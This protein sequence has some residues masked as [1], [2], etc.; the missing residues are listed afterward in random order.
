MIDWFIAYSYFRYVIYML[1][2][3]INIISEIRMYILTGFSYKIR[4]YQTYNK[5]SPD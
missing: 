5:I 4:F 2:K 1:D 3:V